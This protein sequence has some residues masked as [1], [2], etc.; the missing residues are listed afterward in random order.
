MIEVGD[1]ASNTKTITE[2]DV[3]KFAEIVGDS[4]PIHVDRLFASNTIFKEPIAQGML[5]GSLIS[6]VLGT[7][8]PG[9][10]CIYLQQNMRF[11]KA[12]KINDTIS[13]FVEAIE[14]EPKGD[15]SS[16]VTF[17]TWCVN[18]HG[19]TVVLGEAIMK[20]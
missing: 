11:I 1:W 18:Q 8:L 13:A 12:V 2:D 14:I 19:E 15:F 3:L 6:G 4:N 17:K 16:I 7:K 10:G 9:P 5:I 20:V